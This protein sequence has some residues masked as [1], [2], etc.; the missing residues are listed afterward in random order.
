MLAINL[1][2][3]IIATK[4]RRMSGQIIECNLKTFYDRLLGKTILSKF[5]YSI[6]FFIS[7]SILPLWMSYGFTEW[8]LY[9]PTA[10][11]W[12]RKRHLFQMHH[13]ATFTKEI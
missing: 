2:T 6:I 5:I 1:G 3:A 4:L 13:D 12:Y 9:V 8:Y 7:K 11:I 10:D